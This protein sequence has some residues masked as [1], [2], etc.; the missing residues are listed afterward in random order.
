MLKDRAVALP[1][2]NA[3]LVEDMIHGTKVSKMLE[4]F[5]NL[6]P[7]DRPALDALLLRVSE[8]ATELPELQEL[9]INPLIAD[10]NG[11]LALDARIVARA[12]PPGMPRYGHMAILPYPTD[13]ES[14][15]VLGDGTRVKLRP[16]RP[17]DAPLEEAFIAALSPN[18]MR[19]RFLSALR[20]LTPAML[21]RFTQIDYD[22]EMALIALVEA[23]DGEREVGV[24]RYVTLPD[25]DTCEYAIVVADEW[26]G[27]GLGGI[28]MRRLMEVASSR[29]LKSMVGDVLA[30]NEQ[31]LRLCAKLGFVSAPEADDPQ[32]RRVTVKLR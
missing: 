32:M 20:T 2:L 4:T 18:T 6:P 25:G 21:A 19:L 27:R 26:T 28:L 3:A 16:M 30:S 8:I 24:G 7:V 22:R 13:L 31:M 12:P 29:G 9:D 23:P 14:E 10:A 11:V 1:P 17:E 5:R 15:V